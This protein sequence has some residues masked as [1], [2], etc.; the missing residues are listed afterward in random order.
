MGW[1][2]VSKL[3]STRMSTVFRALIGVA[4]LA[5]LIDVVWARR[6]VAAD[7]LP[8]PVSI[9]ARVSTTND[10]TPRVLVT[11]TNGEDCPVDFRYWWTEFERVG[12]PERDIL[13][14]G[15]SKVL[16]GQSFTFSF[17]R[18][19]DPYV[20]PAALPSRW[21]LVAGV[22]RYRLTDF[23][24]RLGLRIKGAPMFFIK[25]NWCPP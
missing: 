17:E 8:P 11:V 10:A 7:K 25:S 19:A 16:A 14:V 22:S 23:E 6:S 2:S 21:R 9:A 15:P 20:G 1:G 24:Y 12:E 18:P 4:V 13:P 5:L 3:R